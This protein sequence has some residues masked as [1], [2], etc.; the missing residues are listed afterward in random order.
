MV[1]IQF[2]LKHSDQ[3]PDRKHVGPPEAQS[4][5]GGANFECCVYK[6]QPMNPTRYSF[7]V[8]KR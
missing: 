1:T 2:H 4:R 3:L 8:G 5:G 7:K 6:Q